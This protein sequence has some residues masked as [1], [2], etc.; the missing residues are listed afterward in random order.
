MS[1]Y[2]L[3]KFDCYYADEF[4]VQGF[5][6]ITLDEYKMYKFVFDNQDKYIGDF[7]IGFGSNEEIYFSNL[8]EY[9]EHITVR[10]LS[11]NEYRSIFSQLGSSYG[12]VSPIKNIKCFAEK[13]GYKKEPIIK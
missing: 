13:L 10:E 2:Y 4:D 8:S 12:L 1:K 3:M 7:D 5:S 11:T 9:L 6:L